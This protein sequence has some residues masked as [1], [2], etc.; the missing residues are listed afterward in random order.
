MTN[1]LYAK[2]GTPIAAVLLAALSYYFINRYDI[3][4]AHILIA[5]VLLDLLLTIAVF[6]L[7]DKF[8]SRK[9]NREYQAILQEYNHS[10]NAVRFYNSLTQ[11]QNAPKSNSAREA[12]QLS[13]SSAL[14]FQ[15]RYEEA[16]DVA[17][18]IRPNGQKMRRLVEQQINGIRN[19]MDQVAKKQK[20]A[21]G[22]EALPDTPQETPELPETDAE[23]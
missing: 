23:D 14:F 17:I 12:L 21:K 16:L 22:Q 7:C 1:R 15:K 19:K 11:M 2:I 13:I 3:H 4:A 9:F 5:I 6:T 8:E 18:E 10:K 20:T